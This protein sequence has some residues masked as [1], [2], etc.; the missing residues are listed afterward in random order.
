MSGFE[1]MQGVEELMGVEARWGGKPV[2]APNTTKSKS[3]QL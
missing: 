2:I 3:A 1:R